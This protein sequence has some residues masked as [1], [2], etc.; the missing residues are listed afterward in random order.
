MSVWWPRRRVV[1]VWDAAQ[2]DAAQEDA[3]QTAQVCSVGY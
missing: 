1:T 2:E 3:A